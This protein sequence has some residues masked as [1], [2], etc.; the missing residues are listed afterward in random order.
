MSPQNQQRRRVIK[1]CKQQKR[2]KKERKR[3]KHAIVL[4]REPTMSFV[5]SES[6]RKKSNFHL[7]SARGNKRKKKWYISD[8]PTGSYAMKKRKKSQKSNAC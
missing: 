7:G 5:K 8:N 3:T 4:G 6:S 2:N 1:N